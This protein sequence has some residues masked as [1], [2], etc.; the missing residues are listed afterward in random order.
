[1]ALLP[2]IS[3]SLENKCDKVDICEETGVY[4]I[5][6]TAG[7]G[8]PNLT[9]TDAITAIVN[10]YNSAG[11]STLQ[12]FTI[13]DTVTNLF[14]ASGL[15][16]FQAFDGASWNQSDGIFKV[17]YSVTE[18]NL[19]TDVNGL[20]LSAPPTIV[21]LLAATGT[22]NNVPSTSSGTGTGAL[23]KIVINPINSLLEITVTT[24]GR[25]Y[26]VG[27]TITI[28]GND[29]TESTAGTINVTLLPQY[30]ITTTHTNNEQYVLFTCTLQNCMEVLIGKMVTECDAEKLDEYK[31]I[32]DQ[33]EVLLYGIKTAFACKNFTRAETLL[34]NAATICTT[35]S[36]CDCGCDCNC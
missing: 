10:I 30:L 32:L 5:G 23:F 20:V 24:T 25:G 31:Q 15:S 35:F 2:K 17:D 28:Q 34:T 16:P 19:T 7:W 36:G 29:L 6:N 9:M 11:T 3:L 14:P 4:A 26:K 21:G 1:M 22:T 13:K 8:S 12:T 27:D 33:L 18:D